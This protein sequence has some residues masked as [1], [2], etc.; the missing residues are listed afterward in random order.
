VPEYVRQIS[1]SLAVMAVNI[2]NADKMLPRQ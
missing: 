2:A 1:T